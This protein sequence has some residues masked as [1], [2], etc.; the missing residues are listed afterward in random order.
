M[1]KLSLFSK[2][3]NLSEDI[4]TTGGGGWGRWLGYRRYANN[5]QRI[6][7]I[8][9]RIERFQGDGDDTALNGV[10][11]KCCEKTYYI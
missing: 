10:D 11:L 4:I 7:G 3:S 6:C 8:Q 5:N 1:F 2:F 9:T